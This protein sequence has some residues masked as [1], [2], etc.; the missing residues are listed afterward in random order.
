MSTRTA[1]IL[2]VAAA[3]AG[4]SLDA[5]AAAG[6]PGRRPRVCL[7]AER[8]T[9]AARL[10]VRSASIG[11]HQRTAANGMPECDYRIAHARRGGPPGHVAVRVNVDDGPQAAWR[12]MRTVVEA[13]QIFGP[14]PKGFRPPAGVPGLGPYA[15][16][17]PALDQLMANDTRRRDLITVTIIWP[18]A[19]QRQM[20]ALARP[21][22]APYRRVRRHGG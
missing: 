5:A 11:E 10:G 7:A 22:M 8:R 1:T 12:L 17:F 21:A 14:V 9:L 3:C 2:V 18:R 4:P 19:S 16:W 15:S 13:S 20:L 6:V